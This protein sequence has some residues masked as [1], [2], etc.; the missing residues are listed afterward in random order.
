MINVV[1]GEQDAIF[2][3]GIAKLLAVEDDIRIVGQPQ[4]LR[5]MRN[6]PDQLSVHVLVMSATFLPSLR[7]IRSLTA[8]HSTAILVLASNE[9]DASAFIAMG[10]CGVV[11]RSASTATF[12]DA[13]RRLAVGKAFVQS[14]SSSMAEIRDDV[15][16]TR[17]RGRLSDKEL[18]IIAC[19]VRGCRNR[20]IAMGLCTTEQGVKN[21]LRG[22]FD[23]IGVSD[24]LELALYVIHHR[25]LVRATTLAHN[26][27]RSHSVVIPTAT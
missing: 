5:Q 19:V 14:T 26:E 6:V 25:M 11:C 18:R 15:V 2:R 22:I 13:V 17:V 12:V 24:R 9:D 23:K 7:A 20:A 16:G 10:V 27:P 8:F 1:I 4:T 3:A 21:A